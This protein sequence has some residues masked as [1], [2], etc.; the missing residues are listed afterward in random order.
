MAA[1]ANKYNKLANR[2]D[3][4]SQEPLRVSFQYIDWDK[5]HFFVHGLDSKFYRQLFDCL[6]RLSKH[7]ESE[8]RQQKA[9]DLNPK[10]I[11]WDHKFITES[12]FPGSISREICSHAFEVRITKNAG[13][14][15]GFIWGNVYYVVW[16]DPCHNLFPGAEGNKTKGITSPADYIKIK[17]LSN[18]FVNKLTEEIEKLKVENKELTSLLESATD[19]STRITDSK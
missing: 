19:P 14:I 3:L 18:E 13:R 17:P 10:F 6:H 12:S 5:E 8:I 4:D 9:P 11:N 1:K 2:F 16:F 15:H 7:Q